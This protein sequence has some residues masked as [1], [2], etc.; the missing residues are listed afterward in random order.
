MLGWIVCDGNMQIIIVAR[1]GLFHDSIG[2]TIMEKEH[3][4]KRYR[5]RPDKRE[6]KTPNK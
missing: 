5:K 6:E 4:E 3:A 2:S 1:Q